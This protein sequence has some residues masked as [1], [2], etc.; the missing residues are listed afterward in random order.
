MSVAPRL[1]IRVALI[2]AMGV[3]VLILTSGGGGYDV[4][5]VVSDAEGLQAGSPVRIADV[6]AGTVNSVSLN[7]SDQIVVDARLNSDEAPVGR[8]ASASI[9]SLNLL[10]Q[11]YVSISKGDVSD[12]AP[13]GYEIPSSH[14]AY[15][16]DLNHVLG[17]LDPDTR[18]RLAVLLNEAGIALSGQRGDV[19]LL[20]G[21]LPHSLSGL[22]ELLSQLVSDNVTLGRLIDHGDRFITAVTDQRSHFVDLLSTLGRASKTVASRQV[23]LSQTLARA[24]GMLS[25][26]RSFLASL[27]TATLPLGAAARNLSATSQPLVSAL[28]AIGPFT[29][30]A[31]PT[32]AL[33]TQ[34]A[35]LL[36]R[37]GEQATPV[38]DRTAAFAGTL[39]RF[40]AI[41]SPAVG[42]MNDSEDNIIS[43]LDN[44]SHAI[45]YQDSLSH[46]FR[47]EPAGTGDLLYSLVDRLLAAE[48]KAPAGYGRAAPARAR[49]VTATKPT[50]ASQSAPT[51]AAGS[52]GGLVQGLAGVVRSGLNGLLGSGVV[53]KVGGVL[54]TVVSGH[55]A[56]GGSS[57]NGQP[58]Q[59]NQLGQKLAG[60]LGYLL[61]R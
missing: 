13:S 6:N 16:T 26:A 32:L 53:S 60:L 43:I 12:P 34:D 19:S 56:P 61:G 25:T 7:R 3:V 10:G 42:V 51:P 14:V 5:F 37:L 27:Q 9:Q 44:W 31:R 23:E 29:S 54:H 20:L 46:Y 2:V 59:G 45:Q 8:D 49:P 1:T 48:G 22:N 36:A 57:S 41:S 33:A 18:A 4:R 11:D 47:G 50:P 38:I 17:V 40:T 58:A 52:P 55:R 30:A 15:S 24:P 39:A 35:P 28:D 21:E